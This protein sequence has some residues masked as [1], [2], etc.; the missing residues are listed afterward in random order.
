MNKPFLPSDIRQPD[1]LLAWRR[2]AT[3]AAIAALCNEPAEDVIRRLWSGERGAVDAITRSAVSPASTGGWGSALVETAVGE[4]LQGLR[5]RSAAATLFDAALR[6]SMNRAGLVTMPRL[7]TALPVPVFVAEGAP[8]PA[9]KG[10]FGN[11]TLGPPSKLAILAAIS[12]ELAVHSADNAELVIRDAIDDATARALDVSVFSTAA[13]SGTRPAG[14]FN[15]VTAITGTAGA[16][17]AAMLTDLKA[18]AAAIAA[19]G[20]GAN[21]MIFARPEQVVAMN[22]YAP[23]GVGYPIIPT[24]SLSSGVVAAIEPAAIASAFTGLP[25]VD[26]GME[27][28]IHYEDTSPAAI[29]TAGSPN[30]V[31]AP[32]R[33]AWQEN[34]MVLRAIARCSWV[35][36][37]VGMVQYI[38][39]VT[40]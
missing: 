10:N 36:R 6:V 40:W 9:L 17:A 23:G 3:A 20:G 11:V 2:L 7:A 26:V 21:T 35:N 8:I 39:E 13:A 33:S 12:N 29:G 19:A 15:G 22:V 18:L 38:E 5:P 32:T 25:E 37:G 16:N 28:T 30:V 34:T 4:F 14:L 24:P 1:V 27:S 31:A